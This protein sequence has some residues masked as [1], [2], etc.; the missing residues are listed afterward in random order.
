M[1]STGNHCIAELYDCPPE[2]INDETYV[3]KVLREA[4]EAGF[5]TLI[6]EVSHKFHPQGVTALALISESHI[7]I[8]TWPE[9]GYVAADVFT[10]GERAKADKACRHLISAFQSARHCIRSLTR[11][12][13]V[14]G[15]SETVQDRQ[16]A[17]ICG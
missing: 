11:G 8:H 16:G 5:A 6:H 4:V 10:C 9:Y 2:L 14:A 12:T 1:E 15:P 7:A 3:K 17:A 13:G